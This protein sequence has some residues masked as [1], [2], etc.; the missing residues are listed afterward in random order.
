[1]A[2]VI[3]LSD[4][5]PGRANLI[6]PHPLEFRRGDWHGGY[7]MM[8]TRKES[9]KY[10]QH[11][12]QAFG[13]PGHQH[14]G[15]VPNH[16]SLENGSHYTVLGLFRYR[17]DE[18]KM[19]K[20]YR[21]AG[22]MECVTNA[23]SSILRTDLLRRFYQTILQERESLNMVWRGNVRH[24]LL[25]LHPDLH[26]PNLFYHHVAASESLKD[27]FSAIERETNEQFD[28]LKLHY[29]FYV[30]ENPCPHH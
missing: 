14:I 25:P 1:M 21:L 3:Q 13:T 24:F 10:E 20:V 17:N 30:P 7:T 22:L 23:P 12:E 27:L 29:V 6:T 28:I 5:F 9:L 2:D 11:R 8:C 26:N 18:S 19:R 4:R 15:Y 16:F